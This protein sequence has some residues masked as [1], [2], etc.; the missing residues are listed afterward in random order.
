MDL[1]IQVYDKVIL[2]AVSG[3]FKSEDV[4]T[5]DQE[6]PA[7]YTGS[8][9]LVVSFSA[10]VKTQEPLF[11]ATVKLRDKHGHKKQRLLFTH[12]TFKAADFPEPR[13][14][15]EF[16][17][18]A[19]TLRV[20]D[21]LK[22]EGDLA[23]V[24]KQLGALDGQHDDMLRDAVGLPKGEAPLSEA[25]REK[26]QLTLKDRLKKLQYLYKTLGSEIEHIEKER[27]KA[28]A[29]DQAPEDAASRVGGAQKAG[30]KALKNAGLV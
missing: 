5:F 4:L 17:N 12:P 2:I 15:L 7:L 1:A 13:A 30:L 6:L 24:S 11:N 26:L 3:D 19:E 22:A 10:Q 8:N 29:G 9:A 16:V 27:K 25:E 18:T 21:I 23:E 28:G 14:A 20:G